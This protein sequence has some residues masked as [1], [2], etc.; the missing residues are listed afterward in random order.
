MILAILQARCSSSRLP[1]KVLKPILNKPMVFR[2]VER[3]KLSKKINKLVLAT[4]NDVSD[5][6][7]AEKCKEFNIDCYR[8][9]LNNVLERFYNA[10]KI[11]SADTIVRLTG[12][13]PLIDAEIIDKVVEKYEQNN[14]DYVSNVDP[15]TFPDGLD[16]EV[17]SFDV[18]EQAYKKASL[19]SE[20][21]H[22]TPY[23]RNNFKKGHYENIID[24]S[25]L[26]W[27]VDEPED[28]E[29]ICKIYEELYS[30]NIRFKMQDILN[31]LKDNEE[32]N[33]INNK[34]K[35]NEGFINSLKK[36]EK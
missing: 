17:F 15:P 4:S 20:I 7:L 11:Y 6:G 29:L 8:G 24:L 22:V 36:D 2:Q 19:T 16:V 30:K 31:F 23:I 18:L 25:N 35:R 33:K 5:D 3:I 21:E 34:I 13:C 9:S 1:G 10:A 26:R 27:T 14:F 28:Y 32:L 12:D